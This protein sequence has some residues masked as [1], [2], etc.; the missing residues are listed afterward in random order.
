[1]ELIEP[2]Y[3]HTNTYS[4]YTLRS[5]IRSKLG[6]TN[7]SSNLEKYIVELKKYLGKTVD[8]I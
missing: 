8:F 5:K 4:I 7:D 2:T 3:N 1:M 6:I